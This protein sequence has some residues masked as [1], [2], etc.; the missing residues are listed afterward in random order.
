[1]F[2]REEKL[3][4]M[5]VAIII[6]AIPIGFW[7]WNNVDG[8][9]DRCTEQGGVMVKTLYGWRCIDSKELM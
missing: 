4:M 1:M 3:W 9:S 2:D 6:V 8:K 5:F 7:S